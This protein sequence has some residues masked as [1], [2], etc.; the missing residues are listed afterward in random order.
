MLLNHFSR[1]LVILSIL[2]IV[3]CNSHAQQITVLNYGGTWKYW[4]NTA[5]NAP[6]ANWKGGGSFDDSG[7]PSG[8][9]RLGFGDDGEIS[10]VPAGC[11]T[12]C[13]P[14]SCATK[15]NTTYFRTS[16]NIPNVNSYAGFQINLIRDDGAV[17][18][19]NG[20]EVWRD[21]MPVGT[22]DYNTFATTT[23]NEG[24]QESE[25]HTSP[26]IPITAFQNGNNIIAI[27][28]HQVNATSSDLGLDLQLMGL[29][30]VAANEVIYKW[31]GAITSNSAKVNAKL[32][33]NTTQARL[34]VSTSA[35]L[36][37]PIYGPYATAD[38][39]NN[40]MAAMSIT[41]LSPNTQYYYGIESDGS[42]DN[43]V[44]DIGNFKTIPLGGFS[45]KFTIGSCLASNTNHPLFNRMDEKDPL[46]FLA[47][48]DLHYDNPNSG[49]D[50]NVHRTPYETNALSKSNYQNFYNKHPIAYVWDDHDFSGN[51]ADSTAAGK[52]NAR[53]AYREYVPHYPLGTTVAGTNA[54]IYQAFTIGRVHFILTDLRSSRRAPTMMG[55]IQKQWFKDQ[56]IY[57]RDNFLII[58]WM[59]SVSFGGNQADNWGG[60]TAER[61][62]LANFFRDNNIRNMFIMSGDAHMVAIDNGTN[63]DFSTGSNNPYD[64][65]V[66]QAAGLSQSGSTKG[67]TYSEGGT[68]PNP[69]SSTGQYGLVEVTDN[70]TNQVCIN[71]TAYRVTSAGTE[72][73]LTAYNFCRTMNA[74]VPIKI[75]S[76]SVRA[77]QNGK[78]ANVNWKTEEASDCDRYIIERS[79]DGASFSPITTVACKGRSVQNYQFEDMNTNNG[80]NYYRIKSVQ[81]DGKAD[82]TSIQ[83]VYLAGKMGMKISPNPVRT[84]LNLALENVPGNE[85]ARYIIYNIKY[86]TMQQGDINLSAGNSRHNIAIQN[87]PAGAYI[88]HLVINGA[89]VN[90]EF[91]V[92]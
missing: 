48:G 58:A 29:T 31:S 45:Y 4:A 26:T 42:L 8:L 85:Q 7:W 82:Y 5:A 18:Y 60:Y 90:K 83:K 36:S 88:L 22:I 49:S 84:T 78:N 53:R 66:F 27:E 41:G 10:C 67:G 15:F 59:S 92:Q 3:G 69:V 68:F 43:S 72:S 14:G 54:P 11:G 64:Y 39:N 73:Q 19:V 56:C 51:D 79:K 71:F 9:G 16:V 87:F 62:E 32:T 65:P 91:I 1:F 6:G 20:N 23:V 24:A 50:V 61:T 40:R 77:S 17:I 33:T 46:F 81:V 89:E 35:D 21:N 86:R 76:F 2:W 12:G 47:M 30:S 80:W 37:S 44:D 13:N 28:L 55:S 34:V 75:T 63:H 52:A 57:A 25:V 38:A 74:T 70:G